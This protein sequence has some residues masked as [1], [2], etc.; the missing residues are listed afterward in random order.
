MATHEI[1]IP[2]VALTPDA[3]GKVWLEPYSLLATNDVWRHSVMRFDEDGNNNAQISTRVGCYGTLH[4]PQNYVG[5]PAVKPVWTATVITGN[6]VWDFD[7]R[8]VG[9]DD[10]ESLDQVGTQESV[11]VTDAAPSAAHERNIPSMS[12][13]AANLAAGDTVEFFLAVDGVDA[14]DTLAGARI[15][16]GIIFEYSDA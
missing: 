6:G 16:H 12:L 10:A 5:T 9:G 11:S 14:A 4:V 7:Y 13:T 2:A 15:L 1:F 8:A 3:S